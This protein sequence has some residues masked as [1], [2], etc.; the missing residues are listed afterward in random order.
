MTDHPS[1][2]PSAPSVAIGPDGRHLTHEERINALSALDFCPAPE[3]RPE[4]VY[5][6]SDDERRLAKRNRVRLQKEQR[7][8]GTR[9]DREPPDL[10]ELFP[11]ELI[12][13]EAAKIRAE[14]TPRER[15]NRIVEAWRA[16]PWYAPDVRVG[17][18]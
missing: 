1:I 4:R 8:E 16:V 9:G 2:V 13:E 18:E 7:A 10:E 15:A 5:V 12:A 6:T 14:W 17:I 3:K 11:P